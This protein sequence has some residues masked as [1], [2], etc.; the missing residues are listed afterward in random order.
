M[1]EKMLLKMEIFKYDNMQMSFFCQPVVAICF[2]ATAAAFPHVLR[3]VLY[4]VFRLL[5]HF[6]ADFCGNHLIRRDRISP[7]GVL[8]LASV[9]VWCWP[10]RSGVFKIS[11]R[12]DASV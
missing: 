12:L 3:L 11:F 8:K 10:R 5:V 6:Q 7:I 4:F 1:K 2:W 9:S